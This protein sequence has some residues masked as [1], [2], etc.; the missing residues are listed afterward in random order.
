MNARKQG[1]GKSRHQDT[2][3][4][5]WLAPITPDAPCGADLEYDPEYVVLSSKTMLRPDAQ[6]GNF[7]GSP[8]PVNWSDIDRDCRRL[9]LRSKDIRLAVLFT[10]CRARLTGA[11]GLGEG[12]A[13]L[14]HWLDLYPDAIHPQLAVDSDRE[15]ALEIR[16]NAI[17]GLTDTDGLLADLREIALTRS[18]AARLQVRDVERAFARPHPADALAPESVTRQLDDLQVQ[19][20]ALLSG[21]GHALVSLEAVEKWNAAHLE[22]FAPDLSALGRLLRL[23][24]R[25]AE[26]PAGEDAESDETI[27]G[28]ACASDAD[29]TSEAS[30]PTGPGIS[31]LLADQ[32]PAGRSTSAPLADR[33]SALEQIRQARLWFEAHEPSSPIP[34]LLR[35]AEHC[36]GKRYAELVQTIPADL[37]AQ[38]DA[39]R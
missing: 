16:A 35:R 25:S 24:V 5:D 6:Y 20:P 29:E 3:N 32:E 22:A 1:A 18:T 10:R 12:L 23:L 31:I 30:G 28:N 8:E 17:Q 33:H 9:M 7:V 39:D 21:F 26:P 4:H 27:V 36:V 13:L 34:V 37:L 2:S 19:N 11:A 14:A 15:A 38:W